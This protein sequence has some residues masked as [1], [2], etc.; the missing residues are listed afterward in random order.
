MTTGDFK[1]GAVLAFQHVADCV[2]SKPSAPSWAEVLAAEAGALSV[3]AGL[4][5]TKAEALSV[6]DE[7]KDAIKALATKAEAEALLAAAEKLRAEASALTEPAEPGGVSDGAG[8]AGTEADKFPGLQ[9]CLDHHIFQ[10]LRIQRDAHMAHNWRVRVE[11]RSIRA[12]PLS[13]F[14]APSQS[15]VVDLSAEARG[16]PQWMSIGTRLVRALLRPSPVY[17][18]R[19][20]QYYLS[21]PQ[22]HDARPF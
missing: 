2:S 10:A 20:E 8:S 21:L 18:A 14:I 19:V 7:A 9:D 11:T 22:P 6:A 16:R 15:I 5:S 13:A 3:E 4:L 17:T 12:T 1:E